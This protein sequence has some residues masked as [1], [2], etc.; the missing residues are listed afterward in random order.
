MFHVERARV[1]ELP[2]GRKTGSVAGSSSVPLDIV[3][4][5]VR[6]N[7]LVGRFRFGWCLLG[8]HQR[9]GRRCRRSTRRIYGLLL[10]LQ[11]F[12]RRRHNGRGSRSGTRIPRVQ[13]GR[14]QLGR[15][16]RCWRYASSTTHRMLLMLLWQ[17]TRLDDVV[18][19]IVRVFVPP[20]FP[21]VDVD[22]L[23]FPLAWW[24]LS[25]VVGP[26]GTPAR[27]L[28]ASP[29]PV[30]C[31]TNVQVSH[32]VED[33]RSRTLSRSRFFLL[34]CV[35]VCLL[36]LALRKILLLLW[37]LRML[38]KLRR[39]ELLCLLLLLRILLRVLWMA[40]IGLLLEV[41]GLSPH[42][43]ARL[44]HERQAVSRHHGRPRIG[45][46]RGIRCSI[47]PRG[48]F[49]PSRVL[50]VGVV[51]AWKDIALQSRNAAH[52][53]SVASPSLGCRMLPAVQSG[54]IVVSPDVG[55]A[56]RTGRHRGRWRSCLVFK[57]LCLLSRW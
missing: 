32:A 5:V 50:V 45:R 38:L 29:D 13:L 53:S 57:P 20:G 41:L 54:V 11:L 44:A 35:K 16:G 6:D 15:Y 30:H 47:Q 26:V 27:A 42:N 10:L 24:L 25:L 48:P 52:G 33:G 19:F 12:R 37:V 36:L 40:W 49:D 21:F 22:R 8:S 34:L 2:T 51:S 31:G 9:A 1:V 46:H 28:D 17:H 23:L 7:L 18:V 56:V 43:D 4:L 55:L 3:V 39:V 14:T